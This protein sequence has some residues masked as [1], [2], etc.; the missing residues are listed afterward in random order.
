MHM[1]SSRGLF[2]H[3]ANNFGVLS[4]IVMEIENCTWL[5]IAPQYRIWMGFQKLGFGDLR[6]F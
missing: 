4:S 6:M 5:D 1:Q 3:Y 2:G